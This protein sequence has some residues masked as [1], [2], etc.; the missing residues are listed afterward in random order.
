MQKEVLSESVKA[1][2]AKQER[3]LLADIAYSSRRHKNAK[4]VFRRHGN[5]AAEDPMKV[6]KSPNPFSQ[7]QYVYEIIAALG[8]ATCDEVEAYTE[9]LHQSVSMRISELI[10]RRRIEWT[11]DR[12][13][14]RSG[15]SAKVYTVA[16]HE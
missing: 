13:P 7:C 8:D 2:T 10:R 1:W 11:G 12:R 6:S 3:A 9:L 15:G 5:L 14:T 4:V 16:H